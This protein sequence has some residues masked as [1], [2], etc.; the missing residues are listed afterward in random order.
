LTARLQRYDRL[1]PGAPQKP[2][3]NDRAISYWRRRMPLKS[4][5]NVR[6][7]KQGLLVAE[8]METQKTAAER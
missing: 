1:H 5:D 2:G 3:A 8:E 6:L 7:W 4:R